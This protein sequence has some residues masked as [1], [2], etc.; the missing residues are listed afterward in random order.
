MRGNYESYHNIFLFKHET[1][2]KN[3]ARPDV[4][5]QVSIFRLKKHGNYMTILTPKYERHKQKVSSGRRRHLKYKI[6]KKLKDEN[7]ESKN[8]SH[9]GIYRIPIVT[10]RIKWNMPKLHTA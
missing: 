8:E 1:R 10:R 5:Y 4:P 2:R 7:G 6:E 3:T 9:F